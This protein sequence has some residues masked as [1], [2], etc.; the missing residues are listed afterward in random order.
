[1]TTTSIVT[2]TALGTSATAINADREALERLANRNYKSILKDNRAAAIRRF[3]KFVELACRHLSAGDLSVL[4]T[5]TE[6]ALGYT[7]NH[8]G[9]RASRV[10]AKRRKPIQASGGARG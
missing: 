7:F 8:S 3:R 9:K 4:S 6:W 1:M 2:E 10:G 5:N